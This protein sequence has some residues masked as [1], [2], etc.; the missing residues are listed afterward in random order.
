MQRR[1]G[2]LKY[3]FVHTLLSTFTAVDNI[4][5]AVDGF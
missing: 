2:V 5:L 1:E 4:F 3:V